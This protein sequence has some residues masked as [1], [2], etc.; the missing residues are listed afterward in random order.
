MPVGRGAT[1]VF[2]HEIRRIGVNRH[3]EPDVFGM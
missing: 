1:L 2:N 3:G